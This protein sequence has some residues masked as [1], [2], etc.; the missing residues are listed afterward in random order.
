MGNSNAKA[1]FIGIKGTAVALDRASGRELWRTALKGRD[2]VNVVLDGDDLFATTRGQI[3]CLNAAS[4]RI[5][6]NN[7]LKGLGYGLVTIA[8]SN[9]Q[10]AAIAEYGRREQANAAAGASVTAGG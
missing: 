2:F 1:V 3:F 4:G 9:T 10:A 5:R 8:T 6:W 7:P